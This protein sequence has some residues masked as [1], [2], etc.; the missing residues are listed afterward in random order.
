MRT[1][2]WTKTLSAHE[3]IRTKS[4]GGALDAQYT[5]LLEVAGGGIAR[6]T[7]PSPAMSPAQR[8]FAKTLG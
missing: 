7:L 6:S 5:G 2:A 8:L 3:G 1:V 4:T